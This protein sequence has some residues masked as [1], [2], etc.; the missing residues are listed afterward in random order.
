MFNLQP[1]VF[2]VQL[3]DNPHE[4]PQ[5]R[6]AIQV[7]KDVVLINSFIIFFSIQMPVVQE[8]F[9]R[10]EHS[11]EASPDPLRREA[12]P[13]QTLL[14]PLFSSNATRQYCRQQM[15]YIDKR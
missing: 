7:Y 8:G 13:V 10:L 6:Q 15:R 5:W 9:Q 3:R 11:D 14:S 4:D 1:E 12:L 2:P